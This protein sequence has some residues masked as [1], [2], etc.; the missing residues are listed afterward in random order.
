MKKEKEKINIMNL[1]ISNIER[2]N[3]LL[4]TVETFITNLLDNLDDITKYSF[5][6]ELIARL[7]NL[8]Q[9]CYDSAD[10]MSQTIIDYLENTGW[11]YDTL[12][13]YIEYS[14][15]MK[16]YL[17][18]SK[19]EVPD[20]IVETDVDDVDDV[21]DV[22]DVEDVADVF[23]IKYVNPDYTTESSIAGQLH[24]P[25]DYE[26]EEALAKGVTRPSSKQASKPVTVSDPA[27]ERKKARAAY[28]AALKQNTSQPT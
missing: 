20:D 14:Q 10:V 11:N 27:E 1:D 15:M 8:T 13:N 21:D 18:S 26:N 7:D 4:D 6:V 28:L 3:A 5:A 23:G 12:P 16:N 19:C 25:N 17:Y 24:Y 9:E 22:E 2:G